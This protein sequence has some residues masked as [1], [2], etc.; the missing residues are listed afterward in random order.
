MIGELREWEAR[1]QACVRQKDQDVWSAAVLRK[2]KLRTYSVIKTRVRREEYLSWEITGEQRVLYA[3]LRSGSHQLRIE[4]GRWD[5]EQEAERLCKICGTGKI[6]NEET[7]VIQNFLRQQT[8]KLTRR[9][10]SSPEA[11]G[12]GVGPAVRGGEYSMLAKPQPQSP[13]GAYVSDA[14]TKK[15]IYL[16]NFSSIRSAH[17]AR[18][19]G[20]GF[21]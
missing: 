14:S 16:E 3:R 6:E 8:Q 13:R 2:P 1:V 9:A 19:L 5:G 18:T 7:L 17:T 4:R 21:C 15:K 12:V 11:I 20:L 10:G